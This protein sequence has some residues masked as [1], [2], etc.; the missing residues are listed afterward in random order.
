MR[1]TSIAVCFLFTCSAALA[2]DSL[3]DVK[4]KIGERNAKH[5]SVQYT[6]KMATDMSQEGMI[7]KTDSTSTMK[8]M[9]RDG[10]MLSRTETKSSMMYKMGEME[11]K[12]DSE[13]LIVVDG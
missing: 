9:K 7:V 12:T 1:R 5:D 10:K 8:Y 2:A 3:E 4:K 6:M 13:S 11:Q